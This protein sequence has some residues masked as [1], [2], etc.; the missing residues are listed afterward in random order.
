MRVDDEY[1]EWMDRE[2]VLNIFHSQGGAN[3]GAKPGL[4]WGHPYIMLSRRGEGVTSLM[5][6][7]DKGEGGSWP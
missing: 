5:T 3:V 4:H 1:D 6:T 7:D 2:M